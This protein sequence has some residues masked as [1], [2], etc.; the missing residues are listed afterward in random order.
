[1][2]PLPGVTRVTGS[3]WSTSARSS[4]AIAESI[5]TISSRTSPGPCVVRSGALPSE[6]NRTISAIS[7]RNA[8]TERASRPS[9]APTISGERDSVRVVS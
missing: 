2:L 3:S 4:S 8:S 5:G 6:G 9:S 1:M 7:A